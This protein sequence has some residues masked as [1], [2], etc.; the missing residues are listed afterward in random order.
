MSNDQ[1]N[2]QNEEKGDLSVNQVTDNGLN[3][4]ESKN[5]EVKS[6]TVHTTTYTQE[7]K[8]AYSFAKSN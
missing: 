2:T 1:E 7:Q 4:N 8:E 3:G 5:D 6:D